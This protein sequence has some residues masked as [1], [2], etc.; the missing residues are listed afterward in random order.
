[1]DSVAQDKQPL[2]NECRLA[3]YDQCFSK[4]IKYNVNN[5]YISPY[6]IGCLRKSLIAWF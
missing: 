5:K 3:Y 6:H 1:M 2:K 4:I